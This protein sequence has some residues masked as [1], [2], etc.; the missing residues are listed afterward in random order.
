MRVLMI[1]PAYNEENSIVSTVQS[2]SKANLKG[3]T[4]DYV[5][6]NDGSKD[7]TK[8][9]CEENKL[10]FVNL[11]VNLGIGGAVQTGYKYALEHDYDVAIQFDG[12]GQHDAAYIKNLVNE[13]KNGAD[14]AIGS[15][16][17]AE[18]SEFK[19]TFIR[20]IGIKFLSF[21]IKICTGKRIY[22]P[23]SG[24][25]AS[26]KERIKMFASEYP[27]DYP[28]PDTIVTVIKKGYNVA[29]IP[30]KMKERTSGKSSLSSPI[31]AMFYM[32]KVSVAIILSS[33]TTRRVKNAK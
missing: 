6:I 8:K 16:Y 3:D 28:E 11:P 22:D 19:S 29:E 24:F 9:V 10:N 18:L 32:I 33:M 2:L 1:I 23:T 7:N 27:T 17:V 13:I 30:V 14:I 4:L 26:N 5:I 15:R 21:L 12:D 25:R 31:K 20:R